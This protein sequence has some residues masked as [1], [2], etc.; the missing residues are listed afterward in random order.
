MSVSLLRNPLIRFLVLAAIYLLVLA[1]SLALS[2]LLRF[3]FSVPPAYWRDLAASAAWMLPLKLALLCFM[4]QFRSLLTFFSLPDATKLALAMVSAAALGLLG[5]FIFHGQ[6]VVPR[7]VILIDL[8]LS[9]SALTSLRVAMRLYRERHTGNPTSLSGRRKRMLVIGAGKA[10]AALCLEIQSRRGLGAEVI[11]FVDDDASK[12]GSTLH[13]KPVMGPLAELPG[14]ITRLGIDKIVIA[15][16]SAAPS[17]IKSLVQTANNFGLDHDILPSIA[18]ML[19][20]RVTISHLRHVEPEDLLGRPPAKLDEKGIGNLV[21]GAVVMVTGAGGSI[22]AAL[23]R[24]ITAKSPSRLL[25]VERSEPALFGIHEELRHA[26]PSME[27]HPLATDAGNAERMEDIFRN[28]KPSLV[29][30][31]AAHKHVPMMEQQPAEAFL[32]NVVATDLVARLAGE[33]G[34]GR[35]V[36]ISTDKAVNPTSVMGATKRIAEMVIA[37]LQRESRGCVYAAVRFGNVLGSS[38]SVVPIFRRQ[39][40]LGGPV[41]VTHPEATRFFMSIS[42]AAGLIM[43]SAWQ[44]RGGETFLLEM[45]EPVK[46][47]DLARHMIEL[48][49]L[50]PH[51]EIEIRCTGLR[52]GEK[53]VEETSHSSETVQPTV[54]PKVKSI[55]APSHMGEIR[56]SITALHKDLNRIG[57]AELRERL[58]RMASGS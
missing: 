26:F 48:S 32:N 24:Q 47:S 56:T 13:T 19:D 57:H 34:A 55:Q 15:M 51:K 58:H 25:L 9:F 20:R 46:I 23:C 10:G 54:H 17:V 11:A 12:I 21:G 3:D 41:T 44:A 52:P 28:H 37:E 49:G 8:V 30:H 38:G 14:I 31:A 6:G 29:F 43:Q 45:G 5:W 36:L 1:A 50:V 16:P 40:A 18:Q 39:I 2:L 53:L 35:F 33:H 4:G 27:L 22:G 42:E 7:G